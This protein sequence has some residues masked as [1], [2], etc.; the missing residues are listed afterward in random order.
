MRCVNKTLFKREKVSPKT[1]RRRRP[2]LSHTQPAATR[3]AH[4]TPHTAP[5]AKP[6]RSPADVRSLTNIFVR[7]VC[8]FSF[9]PRPGQST[10]SVCCVRTCAYVL[11]VCRWASHAHRHRHPSRASSL[12]WHDARTQRAYFQTRARFFRIKIIIIILYVWCARSLVP[13]IRAPCLVYYG[14]FK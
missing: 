8:F 6:Q 12:M 4:L 7:A 1:A 11:G 10:L 3:R 9:C 14:R 2:Y 13:S 5:C